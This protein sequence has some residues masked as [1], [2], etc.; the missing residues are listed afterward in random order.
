MVFMSYGTGVVD[1]L[2][3]LLFSV[4][5]GQL[6]CRGRGEHHHA[7]QL[8]TLKSSW[9]AGKQFV[10]KLGLYFVSLHLISVEKV[11]GKEFEPCI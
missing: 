10:H 6:C 1:T 2:S 3:Y 8:F 7:V 11:P 5:P 9:E 4:A